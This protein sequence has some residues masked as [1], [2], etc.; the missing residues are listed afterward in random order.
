MC[1]PNTEKFKGSDVHADSKRETKKAKSKVKT[2]EHYVINTI[3]KL[4]VPPVPSVKLN[5]R[6]AKFYF[7]SLYRYVL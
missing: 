6:I 2:Q 3:H 4:G 1:Q 5:P 7:R